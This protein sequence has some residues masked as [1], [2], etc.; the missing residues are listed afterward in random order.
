MPLS[1]RGSDERTAQISEANR[2]T[3][4]RVL[5]SPQS[6]QNDAMLN[7]GSGVFCSSTPPLSRQRRHSKL[8][9]RVA[10][11]IH[12]DQD[13]GSPSTVTKERYRIVM[14]GS[15][16]VGKTA[17]VEQFLYGLKTFIYI[18]IRIFHNYHNLNE[19]MTQSIVVPK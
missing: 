9:L 11:E 19:Q 2:A 5:L 6:L 3:P 8:H 7:N 13:S 14:M 12:V 4:S 16:A 1:K 17:I 10:S 15:S 18:I